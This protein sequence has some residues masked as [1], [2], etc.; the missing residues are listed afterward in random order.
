MNNKRKT[1]R[2]VTRD[3]LIS[4]FITLGIRKGD[5]LNVKASLKSIGYVEGGADTLLDALLYVIGDGGTIVTDSFVNI[6][7]MGQ[8]I[9]DK[10]LTSDDYTESYA[11]ALANAMLRYPNVVRGGHPIQKFSAIGF[12][13]KELMLN[14]TP[15]SYAYN[16]LKIMSESGGRNLKIGPDEKVVGV[17]TTHVAI[18][19]LEYEQK[20]LVRGINFKDNKEN[21]VSFE[22]N[23][24][25][26]CGK[27]FNNFLPLY[28]DRGAIV[29]EGKIGFADSKITD[30]KMTLEIEIEKLSTNPAYFICDD[31][32]CINC[33]LSWKFSDDNILLFSLRNL[34]RLK[35]KAIY[36]ALELLVSGKYYPQ[37]TN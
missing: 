9:S 25:G 1:L 23:W 3:Q 6:Y 24:A 17:G 15:E 32:D 20:R 10:S 2:T 29:R 37:S 28:H 27:G 18:G 22:R 16:V 13:A 11:G 19:L 21:I 5:L 12:K 33:R 4:A 7:P 30:M 31:T 26:G 35:I 8:V 14:H 36:K 34:L